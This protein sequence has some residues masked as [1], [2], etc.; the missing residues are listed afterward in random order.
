MTSNVF[1]EIFVNKT[2]TYTL[3]KDGKSIII[4][5][6]PAGHVL[7]QGRPFFLLKL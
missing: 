5:H 1:K 6:V 7:R 4:E 3:E 2:V